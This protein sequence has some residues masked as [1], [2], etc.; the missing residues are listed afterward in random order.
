[1]QILL[2][3][4]SV[5]FLTQH[6]VIFDQY[7]VLSLSDSYGDI[8]GHG[9]LLSFLGHLVEWTLKS[10]LILFL[11]MRFADY[12][13]TEGKVTMVRDTNAQNDLGRAKYIGRCSQW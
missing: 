6:T 5:K 9:V 7:G 11:G 4:W 13:Q 2:Y 1:M 10:S 12:K 8:P 3:I